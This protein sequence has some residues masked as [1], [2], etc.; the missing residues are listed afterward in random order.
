MKSQL[1][2]LTIVIFAATVS[3]AGVGVGYAHWFDKLKVNILTTEVVGNFCFGFT[4]ISNQD[5]RHPNWPTIK[6]YDR[7][8]YG[9]NDECFLDSFHQLGEFPN[10]YPWEVAKDVGWCKTYGDPNTQ[11]DETVSVFHRAVVELNNTYPSYAAKIDINF[12]NCSGEGGA[13]VVILDERLGMDLDPNDT[14]TYMNIVT[15]LVSS[16]CGFITKQVGER[17]FLPGTPVIGS[18]HIEV[19]D[20]PNPNAWPQNQNDAPDLKL[21]NI[22]FYDFEGEVIGP[23][24][25]PSAVLYIHVMQDAAQLS[26]YKFWLEVEA[27]AQ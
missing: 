17:D 12:K 24:E 22:C 14:S 25:S 27:W 15:D 4:G 23:G 18:P 19:L 26:T 6:N 3:L 9:E 8:C 11:V 5:N 7:T 20:V 21:V 1:R 13:D 10:L 16:K 2:N